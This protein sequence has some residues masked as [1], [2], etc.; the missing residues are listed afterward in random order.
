MR[1]F[2][3]VK[4]IVTHMTKNVTHVTLLTIIS[5][6]HFTLLYVVTQLCLLEMGNML[7]LYHLYL[8]MVQF[9]Y[10]AHFKHAQSTTLQSEVGRAIKKS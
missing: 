4:Q 5:P 2:V 7:K 10:V 8:Q 9:K 1:D 3:L 6:I